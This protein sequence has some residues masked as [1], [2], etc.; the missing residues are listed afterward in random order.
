M[1]ENITKHKTHSTW[2]REDN[3]QAEIFMYRAAHNL[4]PDIFQGYF[5]NIKDSHDHL[6][7][8]SDALF[9]TVIRTNY[10]KHTIGIKGLVLWNQL[11]RPIR[12]ISKPPPLSK[13]HYVNIFWITRVIS[14]CS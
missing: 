14:L 12:D 5:I 2:T 11:P 6:T 3:N 4:L 1:R 7:R 9:H 13:R 8:G 10:R